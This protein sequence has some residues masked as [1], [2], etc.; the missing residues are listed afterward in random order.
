M[1]EATGWLGILVRVWE[2]LRPKRVDCQIE[3]V[4]ENQDGGYPSL[5]ITVFNTGG[6]PFSVAR[7]EKVLGTRQNWPYE[8]EPQLRTIWTARL[9][10]VWE[11]IACGGYLTI[12]FEDALKLITAVDNQI[13]LI[14]QPVTPTRDV[15]HRPTIDQLFALHAIAKKHLAKVKVVPQMHKAAAIY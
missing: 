10:P 14:I 11:P 9:A 13:P 5:S 4:L 15:K 8:D 3:T 12:E 2:I 1:S 7:V 6:L